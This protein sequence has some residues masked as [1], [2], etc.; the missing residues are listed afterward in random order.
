MCG[1]CEHIEVKDLHINDTICVNITAIVS[2]LSLNIVV[3]LDGKV[4]FNDTE[5][6][7]N[8]DVCFG[9]PYIKKV[10]GVGLSVISPLHSH[11]QPS[12]SPPPSLPGCRRPRFASTFTT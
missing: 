3:T 12:D 2:T 9:I 4:I 7:E 1:C 5:S 10:R 11:R 6:L 8:P